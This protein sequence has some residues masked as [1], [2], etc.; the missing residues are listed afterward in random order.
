MTNQNLTEVIVLIDRS[1]SMTSIKND[2]EGGFNTFIE[3]QK[4]IAGECQVTVAQ[5]D[6]EYEILYSGKNVQDVPKLELVPRGSTALFDS[7]AKLITDVGTRLASTKEEE[8]PGKVICLVIT[9]GYEN[10]SH[11]F[12]RQKIF[13][14]ITHQRDKY[15]WE[16]IY[17]GANQDA[18]AEG[19]SMGF[20]SSFNYVAN[21][22]GTRDMMRNVSVGISN[23][24]GGGGFTT[25][26][27]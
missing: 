5:F 13:D 15:N 7:L 22:A 14:M 19:G 24:R 10:A 1:G 16:F 6:T 25:N 8:R 18:F 21:S 4:K 20:T 2:M 23:Y 26:Q 12:T 17:L 11:E 27:S 3:E 9:D